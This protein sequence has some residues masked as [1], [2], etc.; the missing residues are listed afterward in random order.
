MELPQYETLQLSIDAGVAH[1]ELNRP[2]KA[3][4]MSAPM[5]I[6]IEHC[7]RWIDA[8]SAIR[9]AVLSG[10]G[11]HFCAGID[12]ALFADLKDASLE[13]ARQAESRRNTILR[14]QNNL[15][16]IEACRKPVLAAIHYTCIG[17]G[18]DMTCCC[19][20][21]YCTED[22]YFS[23]KEIDIAIV[24]DVGTLQRLPRIIG[25]GR[26][27]ELAYTGRRMD[28]AEALA[29]GFVNQVFADRGAMHDGVMA[30]AATIAKRSPLAVRGTKEL[31]LYGRDHS[32][33]DGL[34]YVANWNAGMMSATDLGN[35]VAAGG[36]PDAVRYD[37]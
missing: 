11:K 27:R 37:D 21:R 14:L 32:V 35:T 23:I 13:A 34:R 2:D 3:N 9:V 17:A 6:E 7:F 20:M 8:T 29:S 25:D 36:K 18:V 26:V 24:A 5:W 10:R 1:V 22:A 15:N 12:L 33:A 28:A 4:S 19:D 31:L 30:I 16:A